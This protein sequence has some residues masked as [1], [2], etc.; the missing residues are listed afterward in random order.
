MEIREEKRV[1]R[2]KKQG[3]LLFLALILGCSLPVYGEENISDQPKNIEFEGVINHTREDYQYLEQEIENLILEQEDTEKIQIPVFT[4][5]EKIQSKGT[6]NFDKGKLQFAAA[7]LYF[8]AD[9]IDTL[10]GTYKCSLVEALNGIGTYF[11]TDGT[12]VY[13]ASQSETDT[14]EKKIAVTLGK[15]AEGI[16]SSQSVES[17]KQIQAENKDGNV[18]YYKNEEAQKNEDRYS[19]TAENTGF[20]MFYQEACADNLSAGTAA[21]INGTLIRGNGADNAIYLEQGYREGYTKGIADGLSKVKVQYVYHVHTG[22]AAEGGGCYTSPIYHTHSGACYVEGEHN[23][24]CPSHI[25]FH[26]YDCGSVHDWDGDGHGCDGFI[27]YDCGGHSVLSCS[28]GNTILGYSLGCG[29]TEET[30]ET[31]TIFYDENLSE[32]SEEPAEEPAEDE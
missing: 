11:K 25:A 22:N 24:S 19:I 29:K 9:E 2:K 26:P 1:N 12:I 13:D 17:V 6:L 28:L 10:E 27:L 30:I 8:L 14:E 16:Q 3:I 5:R 21:W 31:A 15:I 7:D 32:L 23:S 4:R 20:P 18:L